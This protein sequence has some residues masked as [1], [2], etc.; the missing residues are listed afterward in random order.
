MTSTEGAL[1]LSN[2][3]I[4]RR[5]LDVTN[6]EFEYHLEALGAVPVDVSNTA[7]ERLM[8]PESVTADEAVSYLMSMDAVETAERNYVIQ[9]TAVP[10]DPSYGQLWGMPAI[11]AEAAWD[12]TTGSHDVLV[13][14]SDTGVDY[15]HA[16]LKDNVWTNPNEIA[17][18]GIDDDDNGYVDDV[19]GW[20]WANDDNDPMDDNSHGTHC[21]G[22][23]GATGDNGVG[24]VGVNWKVRIAALK[25]LSGSG[26]GSLWG[27]T[28]SILYAASIGADVLSA[29]W[30]C[31]G[32]KTSYIE[33]AIEEFGAQGGVFVAAAGNDTNN[34]DQRPFYPAGHTND[35]LLSVAATQS[36]GGLAWFSNYGAETVHVAAPGHYILSTVPGGGYGTKSG[37]SMAAPH[38][39]GMVAML[40]ATSPNAT[41]QEIRKAIIESSTPDALLAG[42]VAANGTVHLYKFL[43]TL[44]PPPAAPTN[45][46]GKPEGSDG[47]H[48]T[49]NGSDDDDVAMYRVRWGYASDVFTDRLDMP[50]TETEVTIQ[51]LESGTEH[52]FVVHAVDAGGNE[53]GSSNEVA[54]TPSDFDTPP[55]VIDLVA[56]TPTGDVVQTQLT[57]SSG[58]ASYY[59]SAGH[60]VDGKLDTAWIS[61]PRATPQ[62]EFILLS[63]PEAQMIH[64][65]DVAANPA[66]PEFFPTDFD[67]ETSQDAANWTVVAGMRGGSLP[68]GDWHTFFFTPTQAQ[69]VR[70]RILTPFEHASGLYYTSLAEV[71]AYEPSDTPNTIALTFTAPGDDPGVGHAAQYDVR[72]STAELNEDNFDKAPQATV[73]AP[74]EAGV[75]EVVL[76]E[77]LAA[78]TTYNFA[79]KAVDEIG[80]V[81]PMSNVAVGQTQVVPPAAIADL[82]LLNVGPNEATLSWTAPGDDGTVG[83]ATAYDM[84]Y[85]TEPLTAA[86]FANATVVDGLDKP[87]TA[88]GKENA[89]VKGLNHGNVY[90]FGV[91]TVDETGATSGLSNQVAVVPQAGPDNIPPAAIGDLA[92]TLWTNDYSISVTT[93]DYSTQLDGFEAS[94]LTDGNPNTS[95]ASTWDAPEQA[96]WVALDLGALHPVRRFR[97]HPSN[98]A[99]Y[100]AAYP[101]AIEIQGSVDGFGWETLVTVSDLPAK[102]QTWNEWWV[103]ATYARYIRLHVTER[104]VVPCSDPNNCEPGGAVEVGELEVFGHAPGG[105]AVLT[106]VAPGDDGWLGNAS[107]Y[108]VRSSQ[109]PLDDSN[110]DS[111]DS[112]P[113]SLPQPAGMIE[114]LPLSNLSPETSY[115]FAIKSVD[116]MGNQS[117]L[118]NIAQIDSPGLPPAAVTDLAGQALGA[119]A[120]SLSWTATGDDGLEGTASAYDVR[121]LTAPLSSLNWANAP[122]VA[123]LPAPN[124]S[125]T[126][127]TAIVPGLEPNTLYYVGLRVL[128]D[129]GNQSLISNIVKLQTADGIAPDTVADLDAGPVDPEDTEP[130]TASLSDVSSEYSPQTEGGNVLD[131]M[132]ETV[133]LSEGTDNHTDEYIAFDFGEAL[134]LGRMRLRS[135]PDYQDL[136]PGAFRL[137]IQTAEN[138]QWTTVLTETAAVSNA[139]WSEW[140]LG[141]VPATKARLVITDTHVWNGQ[142]YAALA[143]VAF[144]T[145]PTDYTTIRL[146]WTA[147]GD[148][149]ANGQAAAYD[150][151]MANAVIDANNFDSAEPVPNVPSPAVGG[152]LDRMDV[153]DLAPETTVCFALKTADEGSNWS[154]V[155]NSACA[156]T[157]GIPPATITTLKVV[158]VS[159]SSAVLNWLATGDDG[160]D[161][162]AAAYDLRMATSHIS[163]D[164]WDSATTVA[165]PPTPGESGSAE[166][167]TVTGLEANT[168]YFFA[169]RASDAAGNTS[170]ISNNA[171]GTT[172]DTIPPSVVTDLAVVTNPNAVKSVQIQ[173]TAPGDSGPKGKADS[174]D[175]R[176]SNA[177]I[178]AANFAQAQP[179]ATNAPLSGGSNESVTVTA[180]LAE[181]QY[182]AALMASDADNNTSAMSNVSSGWTQDE[183]PALVSD[184]AVIESNE[185]SQAK[186]TIQWTATGDDGN[187]GTA[188]SYEIRYSTSFITANNFESATLVTNPP[189][190]APAGNVQNHSLANLT[191]GT[192]Y[193]V[194]MKVTDE[195]GNVSPLSNIASGKTPDGVAPDTVADL[196]ATTHTLAGRLILQWTAP[197]DDGSE[198]KV[199]AYDIRW[200][201]APITPN[202]FADATTAIGTPVPVQG[203]LTQTVTLYSLPDET[204]I[205]VA[206]RAGDNEGNWSGVSNS[207][208]ASTLDVAPAKTTNLAQTDKTNESVTVSWS[209][210]GDDGN[211]GTASAY[212]LRYSLSPIT[213]QT[214]DSATNVPT[215]APQASGSVEAATIGG[216]SANTSIYVALKTQDDKDNWS[217]LS[218][219]L[220][221]QTLDESQ[222]GQITDLTASTGS[223]AGAIQLA[224][225][226]TGD[227]GNE[228]T[229]ASTD[230]RYATEP[231]TAANWANATP[232]TMPAPKSAGSASQATVAGLSGETTYHF[233]MRAVDDD[234]NTG[235]LSAS[236]S[237]TT[238]AVAPSKINDLAA[239]ASSGSATLTWTA[240]GDDANQGTATAYDIRYGTGTAL[241]DNGTAISNPP[242][243]AEAGSDETVVV[244]GL[245]DDTAYWFMIVATDDV[246]E[247]SSPS[248]TATATTP[249]ETAPDAPATLTAT[250]PVP[251]TQPV[252]AVNATASSSLGSKWSAS[253]LTDG[254]PTTAWASLGTPDMSAQS[255]TLELDAETVIDRIEMR[256]DASYLHLFPVSFTLETSTDG[257]AWTEVASVESFSAE[258]A[259]WIGWGFQPQSARYVRLSV[260]ETGKTYDYHYV[261]LS[262]MR[263]FAG[264]IVTG[265]MDLTWVAP[266]D[267]GS[268]G[269]AQQY[270]IYYAAESFDENSLNNA[271]LVGDAPAPAAAGTLQSHRVSNLEGETDF[272]WA[273]RAMDESGNVGPLTPV[274]TATT[275]PVPPAAVTDLGGSANGVDSVVLS[276]TAPGDD[277]NEGTASEFEIRYATWPLSSQSFPLA[278]L[279]DNVPAPEAPGTVQSVVVTGLNPGVAYRFALVTKDEVDAT[280]YL[281]NVAIIT[282]DEGP[283]TTA[284][285]AISDLIALVPASGGDLVASSVSLVTSEQT[286]GFEADLATDGSKTTQWSTEAQTENSEQRIQIDLGAITA[287]D[288]LQIW[289]SDSFLELFPTAFEVRVSTDGLTMTTIA[290][291]SDYT[292]QSGTAYVADAGGQEFRYVEFVATGL[293]QH[294][295]GLFYAVVSEVEAVAATTQPGT[296]NLSWTASGDDNKAGQASAYELRVGACPFDEATAEIVSTDSPL[297]SGSPERY[298]VTGL[299]AGNYCAALYVL[300][301]A[302]NASPLSNEVSFDIVDGADGQTL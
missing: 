123:N 276:W 75:L 87:K 197:G 292:A 195:R 262:D 46:V 283:D 169:I 155:S 4:I 162:Q 59:W 204:T 273:I 285:D 207:A 18:N 227:D 249:D 281:S 212:D 134:T 258:E 157:P 118:S 210:A 2:E 211:T 171:V 266:G 280:S 13:A 282:T 239:V 152:T 85:A 50:A 160:M 264:G 173:W 230:C 126:P 78:E 253:N 209:A 133:W 70:V 215:G 234:G 21:A 179:V 110:F 112:L 255:V 192:T 24:V 90:Y 208:S 225:T 122:Q 49:W 14:V 138:P 201:T 19:Y 244:S 148:D 109:Q 93:S 252:A 132:E 242:T 232:A 37:T 269:T 293:A 115:Y 72:Y 5:N 297:V 34:N 181:S 226:A 130:V 125:G 65:V 8:L 68:M 248:N 246:G 102:P 45:L 61:P 29:S 167:F 86:T 137:E 64:R 205:H 151:R 150:I 188:T 20:D 69:H 187:S 163:G 91:V 274:V 180:L 25:F 241:F 170:T 10:N 218:N 168:T 191:P 12:L 128:D 103:P 243:P 149:G 44:D 240:T 186:L 99:W 301:E 247:S 294:S 200:S 6:E 42:K 62:E 238:K 143:D 178:T 154:G 96:E 213:D 275:H 111:A 1:Y 290:T 174:Y 257:S 83:T 100:K 15:N 80:N 223:F 265:E 165:N 222:P 36:S 260:E 48:L 166:S 79:L 256:P 27:G 185:A 11:A 198:G 106:W 52:F 41:P 287:V 259:N 199:S 22:T 203:G 57:A 35:N 76:V 120:I 231:V 135:A 298:T 33:E 74:S 175:L 235:P 98:L 139:G 55:Q 295:N 43:N 39:S 88:G 267:N 147:P 26:S 51:G 32:C 194:A 108:D 145:D 286:P 142:H 117:A 124:V 271:T 182:Y 196:S 38:V 82:T 40:R 66:Y 105:D 254:D 221:A 193:Y 121:Y 236:T 67:I 296:V 116:E 23:V 53:S 97:M 217:P 190:P 220:S 164:S 58:E 9:I 54:V 129:Q 172:A 7:H 158:T 272:F 251:G 127:E 119:N 114:V 268:A 202:N 183:A 224:W 289:P 302:D 113:A 31:S 136:F 233:A 228:G 141:A 30:G 107:A 279:V 189:V 60:A 84:R 229:A 89:T 146:S 77:Q 56:S 94:F 245:D 278:T 73:S 177:P 131:G 237:A 206:L 95:W 214:F 92:A 17:G 176:I 81:S 153:S 16:D 101:K 3:V 144:H 71:Q 184:L 47:V 291:E 263:A 219:V 28:Q 104:H 161:G 288:D 216:L 277:G 300:D 156:T 63:L 299:D 270:E 261:L 250:A 159:G 284:P 140:A